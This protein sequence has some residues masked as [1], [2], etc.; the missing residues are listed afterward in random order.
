[1]PL[2]KV[3]FAEFVNLHAEI[4]C[5][6]RISDLIYS[7]DT[8]VKQRICRRERKLG[9]K[10]KKWST[11][12]GGCRNCLERLLGSL[13]QRQEGFLGLRTHV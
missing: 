7:A 12:T 5:Q 9:N 13:E 6:T 3:T 11:R 10:I 8:C 1:M 2:S 4:R